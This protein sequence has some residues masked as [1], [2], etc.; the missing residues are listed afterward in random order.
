MVNFKYNILAVLLTANVASVLSVPVSVPLDGAL[1]GPEGLG[2]R[3][4]TTGMAEVPPVPRQGPVPG[5]QSMTTNTRADESESQTGKDIS[6][7]VPIPN[8]KLA[9]ENLQPKIDTSHRVAAFGQVGNPFA[10]YRAGTT[11]VVP[12]ILAKLRT[13]SKVTYSANSRS[14]LRETTNSG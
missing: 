12:A 14:T 2:T 7:G 11:R 4:V 3:T 13:N 8:D 10:G 9:A 6:A 5:S 1:S